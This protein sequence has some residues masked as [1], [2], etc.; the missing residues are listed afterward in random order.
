MPVQRDVVGVHL[1]RQA[2]SHFVNGPLHGIVLD[3]N[4]RPAVAAYRM[5]VMVAVWVRGFVPGNRPPEVNLVH[6][7]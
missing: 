4:D 2:V 5:V 7:V 3:G 6:Q 1:K